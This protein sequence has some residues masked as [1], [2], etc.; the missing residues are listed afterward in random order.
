VPVAVERRNQFPIDR[1]RPV[2]AAPGGAFD[3]LFDVLGAVLE[4]PEIALPGGIDARRIRL[5]AGVEAFDVVGVAAIEE[6]G[7][8]ELFVL[9]LSGRFAT[10]AFY[11][12]SFFMPGM[13]STRRCRGPAAC[14]L[15][16]CI[17]L[18]LARRP[19]GAPP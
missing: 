5:V 17:L 10:G 11:P 7:E 16:L 2:A 12:S 6:G 1:P 13:S 4:P 19:L 18:T 8:Q 15:Q 9:F 3:V 14:P